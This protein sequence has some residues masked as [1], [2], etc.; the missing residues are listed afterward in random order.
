MANVASLAKNVSGIQVRS[1]WLVIL[2]SL[3]IAVSAQIAVPLHPVPITLQTLAVFF[4]GM[5]YGPRLGMITV[6]C[7]LLEGFCGLPVFAE[8]CAGP[9][10]LVDPTIGYLIAFPLA[11]FVCGWL[12]EKGLAKHMLGALFAAFLSTIIV[13]GIGGAVLAQFI[14]AH[15]A[16]I[17]GIKP[18]IFGD[19]MKVALLAAVVP[20]LLRIN[21]RR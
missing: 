21:Q 20:G 4:V 2:G 3:F 5:I 6:L 11:A 16:Y 8:G 14:G 15:Q 19:L 1:L 9:A 7:Y 13:D 18:F 17:V 10:M 12:A